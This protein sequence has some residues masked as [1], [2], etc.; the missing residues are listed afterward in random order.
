MKNNESK[1]LNFHNEDA[2][3]RVTM[4]ANILSYTILTFSMI[5]F[6]YNMYSIIIS[7]SQVMASLPPNVLEKIAIF[8]SK[9]FMDPLIGVFYFLV[10]QGIVQLL[11]IGRDL[12]YR[13]LDDETEGDTIDES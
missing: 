7:W 1:E 6:I 4:A 9:V 13:D 10:L 3:S 8:V 11:N 5:G 2:V 12:Y